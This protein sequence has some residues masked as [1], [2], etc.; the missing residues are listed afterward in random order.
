VIAN[1]DIT[2]FS[3]LFTDDITLDTM[4]RGQLVNLCRL[5]DITP[6]GS[7]AFLKYLLLQRIKAIKADDVMIMSEGVES[8]TIMELRDALSYRGMRSTGHTKRRY[9]HELKS[10]L[11]ISVNKGVPTSLLLLSRAFNITQEMSD[12]EAMAHTLQGMSEKAITSAGVAGAVEPDKVEDKKRKLEELQQQTK[13]IEQERK[14]MAEDLILATVRSYLEGPAAPAYLLSGKTDMAK[15]EEEGK[16]LMDVFAAKEEARLAQEAKDRKRQE[17]L[18]AL[19]N[20]DADDEGPVAPPATPAPPPPPPV[21]PASDGAGGQVAVPREF[22]M[23]ARGSLYEQAWLKNISDTVQAKLKEAKLKYDMMDPRIVDL[24]H[25]EIERHMSGIVARMIAQEDAAIAEAAAAAAAAPLEGEAPDAP[26][27]ATHQ[28]PKPTASDAQPAKPAAADKAEDG[29]APVEAAKKVEAP[30]ESTKKPAKEKREVSSAITDIAELVALMSEQTALSQ[31]KQKLDS[32]IGSVKDMGKEG[33]LE[34]AKT[35]QRLESYIT[36]M[37]SRLKR[38]VSKVDTAIGDKL[39]VLDQDD[40]GIISIEEL[41]SVFKTMLKKDLTEEEL[42]EIIY[43]FDVNNDGQIQ[44]QEALEICRNMLRAEEEMIEDT[45]FSKALQKP[46]I[47]S[48]PLDELSDTESAL[49][50]AILE[51]YR[52]KIQEE[53]GMKARD[54]E[55]DDVRERSRECPDGEKDTSAAPTSAEGSASKEDSKAKKE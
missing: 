38:D 27:A 3:K 46:E 24:V 17:E 21:A 42:D 12:E 25:A 55:R 40:D 54:K 20:P 35:A 28:D 36:S 23:R 1:E 32:V 26:S 7:D 33:S 15:L 34:G 18:A 13:L 43:V 16:R 41:R 11:D 6:F 47:L 52:E 49:Y 30:A 22:L 48:M 37:V 50:G 5:L 45:A 9:K 4:G 10:W 44:V 39:H 8:L 51:E 31:E 14:E 53:K 2:K 19:N 29:E